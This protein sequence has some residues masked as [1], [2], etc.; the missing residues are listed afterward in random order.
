MRKKQLLRDGD[1]AYFSWSGSVLF[2]FC[3]VR[4]WKSVSLWVSHDVDT[5]VDMGKYESVSLA[6][7]EDCDACDGGYVR[8]DSVVSEA[9]GGVEK[10]WRWMVKLKV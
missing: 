10:W 9:D 8:V 2:S 7:A 4:L 3:L 5:L 6:Q 1:T